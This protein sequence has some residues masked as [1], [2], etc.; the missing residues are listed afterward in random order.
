MNIPKLLICFLASCVGSAGFGLLFKV[1][2]RTLPPGALIG[3]CSFLAYD[4]LVLSGYSPVLGAFAGGLVIGILSD[5]TARLFRTPSVVF[6]TMGLIPLVPGYNL[7]QTMEL[8][9]QGDS[10]GGL[11]AC[12]E[13]LLIAGALALSLGFS[14]VLTRLIRKKRI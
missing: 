6:A 8:F 12:M 1:E 7:F 3:G 13:T 4:L 9:V 11:A 5:V 10:A 2:K 14:T